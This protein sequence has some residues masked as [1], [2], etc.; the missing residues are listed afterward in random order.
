MF[1]LTLEL[2]LGLLG[3]VT[4]V[5]SV[6]ILIRDKMIEKP[7]L[8]IGDTFLW[9]E[10]DNK[11]NVVGKLSFIINNLGERSTTVT[12]INVTLGDHVE[13][14]EGLRDIA[15]HSSIRYPENITDEVKLF[16][17]RKEIENLRIIVMHTHK[18]LEKIYP[19]PQAKEWDKHV[20]WKGG[21][22]ALEP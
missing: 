21:P 6:F 1:E 20:L 22:I 16:T 11:D 2:A 10:K 12:R 8:E 15:P 17:K 13:V 4:G 19:L 18:T 7:I 9:L 3:S 14:I 5:V